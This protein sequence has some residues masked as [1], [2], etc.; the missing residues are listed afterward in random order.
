MGKYLSSLL[1]I[2]L[3]LMATGCGK[4]DVE[5]DAPSEIEPINDYYL[6]KYD[7]YLNQDHNIVFVKNLLKKTH[8]EID[9]EEV[10]QLCADFQSGSLSNG[11]Y[12][13]YL[14]DY[15][16]SSQDYFKGYRNRYLGYT[17]ETMVKYPSV[18]TVENV[19]GEGY[20]TLFKH[21]EDG[22]I[23]DL[24]IINHTDDFDEDDMYHLSR[25]Q[26]GN[27]LFDNDM[28]K[29]ILKDE[30]IDKVIYDGVEY[31]YI[32]DELGRIS[33]VSS[34]YM[35]IKDYHYDTNELQ[36][37]PNY[38]KNYNYG[39]EEY[40]DDEGRLIKLDKTTEGIYHQ[41]YTFTYDELGRFISARV[42][43]ECLNEEPKIINYTYA[44]NDKGML[45]NQLV[46]NEQGNPLE[47]QTIEYVKD[48]SYYKTIVKIDN[49][50][51]DEVLCEF[52]DLFDGI[53]TLESR[54]IV[55]GDEYNIKQY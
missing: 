47:R 32:Y 11:E 38:I 40:Y 20:P 50:V 35:S 7:E 14:G 15:D 25:D 43:E 27:Y 55:T 42:I 2:S 6:A 9:D 48:D 12:T 13:Y 16:G 33:N 5:D 36:A 21:N 26:E 37:Y 39:G 29:V 19:F 22:L 18:R 34:Q 17:A 54:E 53:H 46:C 1:C 4:E 52:I 44:Y 45:A 41:T 23:T 30:L 8:N 49:G 31:Q 10:N 3:L 24:Y 28:G 51:N